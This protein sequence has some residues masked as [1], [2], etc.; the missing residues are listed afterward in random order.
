MLNFNSRNNN[1]FYFKSCIISWRQE[2][3]EEP[4]KRELGD[5]G[6]CGGG[7]DS[8]RVEETTGTKD[9]KSEIED[10]VTKTN[11]NKLFV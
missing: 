7:T 1:L 8:R 5:T 6:A 4:Q 10:S 11:Q 3:L 2:S 9:S